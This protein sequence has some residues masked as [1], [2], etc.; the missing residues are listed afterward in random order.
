MCL[1]VPAKVVRILNDFTVEV[2]TFGNHARV[3]TSLIEQVKLGDYVLVH[4]GFAIEIVDQDSAQESLA[5]WREMYAVQS[6]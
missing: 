2:E 3:N 1:A 5:L 4:A 6:S